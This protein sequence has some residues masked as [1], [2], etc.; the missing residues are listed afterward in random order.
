MA[1]DLVGRPVDALV[2]DKLTQPWARG[3]VVTGCEA[4]GKHLLVTLASASLDVARPP[5][6]SA[7]RDVAHLRVH[8]GMKGS[9][10]RYRPG[11][12]W[13]RARV[14]ARVELHTERWVF[15]CFG[16]KDV[17]VVTRNAP[18]PDVVSHL[19]PDLLAPEVDVRVIVARAREPRHRDAALGDLLLAQTVAAGI[20][21][22]YKSEVLFLEGLDP[23]L[24]ARA[25]DDARLAGVYSHARALMADN[26]AHGGWRTTTAR[27][28]PD[29]PGHARHWV[30]RRAGRPCR[31]CGAGILS[32]LQG[33]MA[34]RTYWCPT[35]QAPPAPPAD[36]KGA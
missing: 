20:G 10:H 1:P 25:L 17:E 23:W 36:A 18:R 27:V 14:G 7:S 12:P 34:R 22:V 16:P 35:C 9:W 30:Y 8:L 31:R 2:L 3:A 15:V 5:A 19:G 29:M 4:V 26:L 32:R 6:G 33:P 11:E 24:P 21:N 13:Q 28:T